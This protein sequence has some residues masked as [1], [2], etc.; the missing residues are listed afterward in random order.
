MGD[1]EKVKS[2]LQRGVD[3]TRNDRQG[4]TPLLVA[5]YQGNI[6]AIKFF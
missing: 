3:V 6:E 5:T 4:Y 1:M 2:L